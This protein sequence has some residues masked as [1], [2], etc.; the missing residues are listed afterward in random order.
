M[1]LI[2][3]DDADVRDS[4]S[5]CLASSGHQVSTAENGQR[6][7]EQLER[8]LRPDLI[9]LDLRMPLVDGY[10]VLDRLREMEPLRDVPVL[11]VT[12][13]RDVDRRALDRSSGLLPKPIRMDR[14]LSAVERAVS[15]SETSDAL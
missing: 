3:D 12:A 14:L 11:L 5:E 2:V 13:L 10:Q 4:L 7:L 9:L 8:G 6:A 15:P 1:I